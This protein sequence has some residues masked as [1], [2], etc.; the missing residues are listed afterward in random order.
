MQTAVYSNVNV[1]KCNILHSSNFA[2]LFRILV[3][4]KESIIS[5]HDCYTVSCYIFSL[6]IFLFA[7]RD[8]HTVIVAKIRYCIEHRIAV[9][10]HLLLRDGLLLRGLKK[11]IWSDM[12]KRNKALFLSF[13]CY[14]GR[15]YYYF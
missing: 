2:F 13:F 4:F 14:F 1:D 15:N 7:P 11:L 10:V 8:E 3:E 12:R 5:D 6:F 9:K